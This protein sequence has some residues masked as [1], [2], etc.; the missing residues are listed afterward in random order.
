MRRENI[1]IV[2]YHY[3]PALSGVRRMVKFA[4]FLPH[5]GYDPIVLSATPDPC[6]PLD[7]ETLREVEREGYPIYRTPAFDINHLRGALRSVPENIRDVSTV[8]STYL[9][10]LSDSPE[11]TGASHANPSRRCRARNGMSHRIAKAIGSWIR[12]WFYLPDDCVGWVP[13]A[14]AQAARILSSRPIRYVLT[15]SYPNSTHLIGL[16]LKR[17]YKVYWIADFRDGWTTNPYF[18]D[19][20]TPLHRRLNVAWERKVVR[21]SDLILT[22]SSP[23]AEHLRSLT[24]S[25]DKVH[26]IPNGY[27]PDDFDAAPPGR[28]ERFTIVYTGTLFKQRSPEPFFAAMRALFDKYPHIRK[29]FSALF[30]TQWQPEHVELIEKYGLRGNVRNGGLCPY[31][32]AL[33]FQRTANALLVIE[34]PAAYGEVMLTQ[35]VFEYLACGKPI[36]AITPEN[37]L[38][39][40]IR[41]SG[42][43]CVV[44][45]DDIP[46]LTQYLYDLFMGT[47]P[48]SPRQDYISQFHRREQ[49]RT[50]AGLM[51]QLRTTGTLSTH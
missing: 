35:K 48:F 46:T 23:I 38:A 24:D 32:V 29:E 19:Y 45:P 44:S 28:F 17:H 25:P 6:Q 9:N 47:F 20:P 33:S 21:E 14:R 43:G 1:L 51:D 30:L 7:P 41:E 49:A 12:P 2:S 27:D 37:A 5:F 15:T 50:L 34:G 31:R 16:W 11:E 22:V 13:F 39:K 4:K 18:A 8:L 26:V 40:L 10:E 36:L 42:A 3:P